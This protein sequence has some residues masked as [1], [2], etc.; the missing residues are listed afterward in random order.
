MDQFKRSSC[1]YP[2]IKEF[3]RPK[4]RHYYDFINT[5]NRKHKQRI[6]LEVTL[7]HTEN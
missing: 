7:N 6:R 1:Y 4:Q 3:V 5:F 2:L